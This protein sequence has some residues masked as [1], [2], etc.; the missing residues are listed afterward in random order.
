M[1]PYVSDICTSSLQ[2]S[3]Y[4]HFLQAF[5]SLVKQVVTI[6]ATPQKPELSE[7]Y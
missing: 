7:P 6:P 3:I 4:L 5:L 1:I 2:Y